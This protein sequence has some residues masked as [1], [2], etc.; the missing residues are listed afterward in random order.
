MLIR[1]LSIF[2]LF[3]ASTAA[4]GEPA[5]W[6]WWVSKLDGSRVCNQTP[7]GEGW[8]REPTPFKDARCRILLHPR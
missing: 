8:L 4:I 2:A 3:L 7:L 5:P 1:A 6:Y